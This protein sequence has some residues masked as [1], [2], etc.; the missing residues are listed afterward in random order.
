MITNTATACALDRI[1][2]ITML[3]WAVKRLDEIS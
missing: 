2:R 1:T 3:L